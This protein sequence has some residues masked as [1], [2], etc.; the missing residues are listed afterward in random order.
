MSETKHTPGPW[1][2]VFDSCSAPKC[3]GEWVIDGPPSGAHGQFELE[4]DARLIAAAPDLLAALKALA[5]VD[6]LNPQHLV[7]ARA[8]IAKAEAIHGR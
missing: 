6:L 5:E 4:A 2:V 7:A 3:G 1:D 8:A